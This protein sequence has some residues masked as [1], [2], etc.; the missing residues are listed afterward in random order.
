M[1]YNYNLIYNGHQISPIV[2]DRMVKALNTIKTAGTSNDLSK[3]RIMKKTMCEYGF[4]HIK[5]TDLKNIMDREI[6][7]MYAAELIELN[8]RRKMR[9]SGKTMPKS[10]SKVY[11]KKYV[12]ADVEPTVKQISCSEKISYPSDKVCPK[13]G[14]TL[15]RNMFW[16]NSNMP[17]GL[18]Y[19]CKDCMNGNVKKMQLTTV[20]PDTHKTK[21]CTKCG[22]ELPMS[23]FSDMK[24]S[25]DGKQYW[26]KDC[27]RDAVSKKKKPVEKTGFFAK[28]VNLVKSI[29]K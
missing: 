25:K 19:W 1:E 9:E 17:D 18:Q 23:M 3:L 7:T 26:C 14:R 29:F 21:K 11:R 24:K 27:M 10:N 8:G 4:T 28:V 20:N 22:R 6:N 12:K 2:I 15:N 5:S 16:R 13:C